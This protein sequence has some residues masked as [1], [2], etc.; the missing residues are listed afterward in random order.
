MNQEKIV[1]KLISI[2]TE[3]HKIKDCQSTKIANWQLATASLLLN[4]AVEILQSEIE[5]K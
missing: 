5:E 1:E 2:K 4:V 3:L